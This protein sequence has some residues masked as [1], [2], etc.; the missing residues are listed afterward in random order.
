MTDFYFWNS[1]TQEQRSQVGLL[2]TILFSLLKSHPQLMP[3]VLPLKY[4][5]GYAQA[6]LGGDIS[7]SIVGGGWTLKDLMSLLKQLLEQK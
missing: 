3:V 7:S 2:R 4:A 6:D 5:R 1:G